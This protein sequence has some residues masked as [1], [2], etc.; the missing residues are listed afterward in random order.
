MTVASLR[1]RNQGGFEASGQARRFE[2]AP[3]TFVTGAWHPQADLDAPTLVL[4]HG[5]AG[6]IASNYMVGTARI[7]H[8]RGFAVLCLNARNSGGTEA[9]S[10][11]THHGALWQDAGEVIAQLEA[12]RPGRAFHLAGF[13]LGGSLSLLLAL[14]P[15]A[16]RPAGL[17][18]I[19][20]VSPPLDLGACSSHLESTWLGK[21][22]ARRFTSSLKKIMRERARHHGPQVDEQ[23][24]NRAHT[25]R[26][27]DTVVTAPLGGFSSVEA[28]YQAG[29][30]AGRMHGL[31]LPTRVLHALDDPLIPSEAPIEL[32]SSAPPCLD[33]HLI[34]HGGHVAFRAARPAEGPFGTDLHCY[35][36]ESRVVDFAQSL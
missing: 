33:L 31:D 7:A 23:A 29:S 15:P 16:D 20:A 35:W 17:R 18:S 10:Q 8:G 14:R 30:V 13:S 21:L 24:M 4:Q 27:F 12:E 3:G 36:A 19:C 5:L 26:E 34:P 32:A 9:L 1:V 11:T 22:A 25:V 6:S 2:V 28:Y